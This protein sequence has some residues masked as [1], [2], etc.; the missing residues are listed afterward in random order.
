M[1]VHLLKLAVGASSVPDLEGW[2]A[3]QAS[4]ARAAGAEPA[5]RITTRMAPKRADEVL[6]GGSLYWVVKGVV[7]ARQRILALEP[8]TDGAGVGRIRILLAPVVVPVRPRP[9]RPFQGW[10]YLRPQDAPADLSTDALSDDMP[11]GMRRELM[12]LC[13]I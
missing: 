4:A 11:A 13:L 8:F 9:C 2:V 1:T 12:E 7:A 10:R 6:D 5:A 3:A